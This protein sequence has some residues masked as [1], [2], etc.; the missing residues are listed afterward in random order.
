[1][2]ITSCDENKYE[3]RVGYIFVCYILI[4]L[5]FKIANDT[6]KLVAQAVICKDGRFWWLRPRIVAISK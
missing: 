5:G 6:V 1:M 4:C 2:E 3:S